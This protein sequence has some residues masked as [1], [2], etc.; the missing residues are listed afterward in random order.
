[1]TVNH[2]ISV[3]KNMID[4]PILKKPV[5]IGDNV[6]VGARVTILPGVTI[7][8]NVV[9]AAGSVVTKDCSSSGIY[10]V[11]PAK[12]IKKIVNG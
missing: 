12:I 11:I 5:K 2:G 1:M 6:W 10:G 7:G 8:D 4:M 9:I 3:A